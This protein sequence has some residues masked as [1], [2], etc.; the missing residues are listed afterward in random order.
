MASASDD[1]LVKLWDLKAG[2]LLTDLKGHQGPVNSLEFHPN[3]FLLA[4][5]SS[6]RTVRFWDLEK[7]EDVSTSAAA[8]GPVRE[9][10]FDPSGRCLFAASNDYLHSM[11]WEPCELYD[12]IFC[13]W[14]QVRDMTISGGRLIAGGFNQN[15]VSF[16][17]VD[18]SQVAPLG[19]PA[20]AP[21]ASADFRHQAESSLLPATSRPNSNSA[22]GTSAVSTSHRRNFRHNQKMDASEQPLESEALVAAQ[23]NEP[24]ENS[25]SK[26]CN[27]EEY[28]RIFRPVKEIA[29]RNFTYL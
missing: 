16:Y 6:D 25:S 11:R 29:R 5:G 26:I 27:Q 13:Q 21:N 9:I 17:A 18:L 14:R 4:S 10:M 19:T 20:P 8:A 2:R 1:G 12:A 3:E 7:M 28:N 15:A 24:L 23:A 22:H